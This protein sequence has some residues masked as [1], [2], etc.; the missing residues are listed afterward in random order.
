MKWSLICSVLLVGMAQVANAQGLIVALPA[1][2]TWVRYE[3][4]YTQVVNQTNSP[5]E[6]VTLDFRRITTIKSVGT[7]EAEY[8]GETVP[9][10][11][12]EIKSE[13]GKATE[14]VI[15]SGPGQTR[16]YKILVPEETVTAETFRSVGDEHPIHN[17]YL[18]IVK[19]YR[20]IDDQEPTE[21]TTEVFVLYPVISLLRAYEDHEAD[22][23]TESVTTPAGTFSSQKFIG[24][25][26]QESNSERSI[27]RGEV[28]R[29]AEIPFGLVSWDVKLE[30][31][32]KGTT[33]AR[34]DFQELMTVEEKMEAIEI[35]TNAQSE[36]VSS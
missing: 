28:V 7:E 10:R 3:G 25:L 6:A 23:A 9:C 5:N 17:S 8:L 4:T 19:G 18:T 21:I 29:S 11:W 14:G 27:N 33:E 26:V 1:D 36:I 20:K 15:A 35:G 32:E 13:T 34:D 2:G 24:N 16:I 30:V 12:L 22:P 31:F